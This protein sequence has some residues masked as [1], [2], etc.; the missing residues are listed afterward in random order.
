M[1]D[2][3]EFYRLLGLPANANLSQIKAAYHKA[4]HRYHPDANP[5]PNAAEIFKKISSIYRQLR[6]SFYKNTPIALQ[7]NIPEPPQKKIKTPSRI[8]THEARKTPT[9]RYV[10]AQDELDSNSGNNGS[11]RAKLMLWKVFGKVKMK[12]LH[13]R[14]LASSQR[15]I[16]KLE[17]RDILARLTNSN[18]KYVRLE[19][20]KVLR[21]KADRKMVWALLRCLEKERDLEV[22]SYIIE[23]LGELKSHQA[24][25]VLVKY[26]KIWNDKIVTGTIEALMKI[27]S[28]QAEKHLLSIKGRYGARIDNLIKLALARLN[29]TS[30]LSNR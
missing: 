24:V 26:L 30:H 21:I 28:K 18:N 14:V 1:E 7:Q 15:H 9:N 16:Y 22:K 6:K 27:N 20:A 12:I 29:L 4:V 23:T 13:I 11:T 8:I 10:V 25:G 5:S 19:A 2:V 17:K 3:A